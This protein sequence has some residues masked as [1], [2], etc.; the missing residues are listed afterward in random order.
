MMKKFLL[1]GQVVLAVLLTGMLPS[2]ATAAKQSAASSQTAYLVQVNGHTLREKNANLRRPPASLTKIM[3]ALIVLENGHLDDI[4]TVSS[5][6]AR[7]TGSRIGL[8]RGDRFRVRDLLAASL[9]ASANDATRALADHLAGNQEAFVHLMNER[10]QNLKLTG[11]RFSNVCG[12]DHKGLYTTAHDLVILTDRALRN[13]VFTDLVAR[14]S[15]RIVTVKGHR[16]FSF[17]NKNRLIGRYPG[18]LGVK[19]GT[20]PKAGQCLVAVAQRG[21]TKVFLVLL[22]MKPRWQLAPAMLDAAFTASAQMKP[23]D[24]AGGIKHAALP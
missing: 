16:V 1:I 22:N 10:A 24:T 15:M 6:A 19:T 21:E 12:H 11:T 4:V 2:N 8:R 13:P 23:D 17:K 5:S 18:A 14:R 7:E 20:T 3:T 9:M